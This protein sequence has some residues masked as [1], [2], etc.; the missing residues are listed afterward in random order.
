MT[1]I[2]ES[3]RAQNRHLH[4]TQDAYGAGTV[5]KY[6]YP[7]IEQIAKALNVDSVLDYG[8]GK[9]NF[10]RSMPGFIVIGYDPA[11]PDYDSPPEPADLVICTDVLEHIEPDCLDVVLD[12][13]QR[14][15][16]KGVFLT[17]A[18]GPAGRTLPDGRN[19]HLIQQPSDW[20][21]PKIL[22]RWDMQMFQNKTK[23]VPEFAV[24]ALPKPQV[25][26]EKV[27]A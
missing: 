24:F 17:I 21:L 16:R 19:A 27:A 23:G 5:T 18:T 12:D 10:A 14:L 26:R 6:W 13:L 20:W 15:G 7:L 3:Y 22:A 4:E 1:L 11:V 9:G 25:M 8:C 2:T